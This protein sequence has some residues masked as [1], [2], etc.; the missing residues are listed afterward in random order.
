MASRL[1]FFL[2]DDDLVNFPEC[3]TE[4]SHG[5]KSDHS[6]ISLNIQGSFITPGKGYWKFNNSHLLQDDFKSEIRA[7]IND[8]VNSSF[9]SHRSLW[10]TIKFKVRDCSIQLGKK[11]KM[12]MF[13]SKLKYKTN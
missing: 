7:L 12:I 9:D 5:Y 13:C 2:I 1:Y 4:V 6:Y 3:S 10:D 8:T 11:V